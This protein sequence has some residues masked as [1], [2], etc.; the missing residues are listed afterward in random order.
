MHNTSLKILEYR[1]LVREAQRLWRDADQHLLSV[2]QR[3]KN[4]PEDSYL[5]ALYAVVLKDTQVKLER[6]CRWVASMLDHKPFAT[7]QR[8]LIKG[9]AYFDNSELRFLRKQLL[10]VYGTALS[11]V[12]TKLAVVQS[13]NNVPRLTADLLNALQDFEKELLGKI[14][15]QSTTQG[16]GFKSASTVQHNKPELNQRQAISD[17]EDQLSLVLSLKSNCIQQ[18]AMQIVKHQ[19]TE[20]HTPFPY[21][22][23]ISF[24]IVV[25]TYLASRKQPS[26]HHSS[27]KQRI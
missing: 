8:A 26:A 17:L 23:M 2:D 24:L 7:S 18:Q 5:Q 25:L 19:P 12:K 15:S 1:K 22:E 16:S 9:A 27:T 21:S 11:R 3:I 10:S 20:V 6:E 14:K 13:A 4:E